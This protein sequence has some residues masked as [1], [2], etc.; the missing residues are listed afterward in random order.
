M[1]HV[2]AIGAF[3]GDNSLFALQSNFCPDTAV[4]R[5]QPVKSYDINDSE[6]RLM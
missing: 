4:E 5:Q 6:C 3:I 1:V 2:L